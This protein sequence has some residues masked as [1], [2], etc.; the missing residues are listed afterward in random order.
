MWFLNLLDWI[1]RNWQVIIQGGLIL[2][3]LSL[4][5]PIKEF[6]KSALVGIKEG[7]DPLGFFV[8]LVLVLLFIVISGLF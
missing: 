1:T 5:K 4:V 6:L 2:F 8:V 7:L 3:L